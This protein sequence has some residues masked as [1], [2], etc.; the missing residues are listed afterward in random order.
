M[1]CRSDGNG[2]SSLSPAAADGHAELSALPQHAAEKY[3]TMF[4]ACYDAGLRALTYSNA[5]HLPPL[6]LSSKERIRRLETSDTVV[7]LFDGT[8]YHENTVIMES[9]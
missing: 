6:V 1:Y 5:G 4:L 7:G 3:A 9:G 8:T 2:D